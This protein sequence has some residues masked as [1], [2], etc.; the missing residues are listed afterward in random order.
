MQHNTKRGVETCG[1]LAGELN[2]AENSFTVISLVIPKQKGDANS[3]EMQNEEDMIDYIMGKELITL[4]WIHSHPTQTCFLSSIDVHTQ[5]PYQ[6]RTPTSY[7]A[8]TRGAR[9][10]CRPLPAAWQ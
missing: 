3:V 6:V 5:F 1:V 7:L 10:W 2:G 9:P 4:G 8:R